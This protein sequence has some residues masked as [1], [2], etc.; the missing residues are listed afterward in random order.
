[1][2]GIIKYIREQ[3]LFFIVYFLFLAI[4]SFFL[5]NYSREDT[6]RIISSHWND[7]GDVFFKY[8]T[9]VG[10]FGFAV[11]IVIV[12]LFYS[13]KYAIIAASGF[14]GTALIT[15]LLKRVVFPEAKRP[16]MTLWH[17]YYY[18][19]LHTV[20][21]VQML[22]SNSFPSGH[23]TSAFSIFILLAL[24]SKNKLMGLFCVVM[25]ILVSFSRSYLGHHFLEDVFVGSLIGTFG[26]L[27]TYSL[28]IEKNF[29]KLEGRSLIK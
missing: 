5:V 12:L 6:A 29:G 9:Y 2:I 14:A 18:G 27:L 17:E 19:D 25:A 1:M 15:Q 28:L 10:D 21:G 26:M 23:S 24:L 3:Y 20:E 7:F 8:I 11:L 16:Y 22:K 4:L 13:Y